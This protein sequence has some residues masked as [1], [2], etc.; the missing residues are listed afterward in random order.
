MPKNALKSRLRG[1]VP[2]GKVLCPEWEDACPEWEDACP[3]WE[4]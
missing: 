3:E 2:N 4:G 1:F